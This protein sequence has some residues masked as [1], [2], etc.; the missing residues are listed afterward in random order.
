MADLSKYSDEELR[1]MYNESEDLS[2][3]SDEQLQQM[4]LEDDDSFSMERLG[5]DVLENVVVPVGKAVDSVTGA[6]TRAAV[7][8]AARGESPLSAFLGQFAEDPE[9]ASTGQDQA[10]AL[11]V[12][13]TALSEKL[14]GLYNPTGEGWRLQKGG[15]ADPTAS[16]AAGLGLDILEDWSNFIPLTAAAKGVAKAG[17]AAVSGGVRKGSE[18]AARATDAVTGTKAGSIAHESMAGALGSGKRALEWLFD[19]KL[20]PEWDRSKFVAMREG[21]DLDNLSSA[22][23]F[24]PNSFISRKERAISEGPLGEKYLNRHTEGE[25]QLQGAMERKI[26]ET[27]RNAVLSEPEA[28]ALIRDRFYSNA[29]QF[30][31][32]IGTTFKTVADGKPGLKVNA[33]EKAK[34][35]AAL[36]EIGKYAEGRRVRGITDTQRRQG[37]QLL[38]AI[39]AYRAG[40]GSFQQATEALQDIGDVA[41]GNVKNSMADVPPDVENLRNLYFKINNALVETVRKDV[42]P[43]LADELVANNKAMTRFFVNRTEVMDAIGSKNLSDEGVF[44]NL[45]L[46]GDTKKI[47][48]LKE[49]LGEDAMQRLKGAFLNSLLK[50]NPEDNFTFKTFHNAIARKKNVMGAL[51]SK[52]EMDEI[53]DLIKLGYKH[54][55]GTLSSSGTGASNAFLDIFKQVPVTVLGEGFNESMKARARGKAAIPVKPKVSA[56]RQASEQARRFWL[57]E[58]SEAAPIPRG[59]REGLLLKGPQSISPSFYDEKEKRKRRLKALED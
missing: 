59:K 51:F 37:E 14:P 46:N 22:V 39:E 28:G 3:Y 13:D 9:L 15:W 43:K 11:G 36:E 33:A 20:D 4:L 21:V 58:G 10:R 26:E 57:D 45:I 8:A 6:P 32:E 24:G 27:G 17:T 2:G 23:E 54:G 47:A 1:R 56:K 53:E 18:L 42:N 48:A 30:F 19:P 12:P 29:E 25:N 52:K 34:V 55:L 31:R 44:R 35:E 50:K 41:F 49:L 38:R 5:R 16:G 7:S 40:D